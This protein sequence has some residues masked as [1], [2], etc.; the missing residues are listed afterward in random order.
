MTIKGRFDLTVKLPPV[1]AGDWELR[2]FT[3]M[4]FPS[5]GIVQ[6]FIDEVPQGIPFDMRPEGN[7]PKVG[8]KSDMEL[9]EEE[10]IAAFDRQFHNRGWM[11][12]PKSYWCSSSDA[13]GSQGDIFR[14]QHRTLRKV[15]GVFHSDGRTDHYLRLQQKMESDNN[16]LNFDFIELCPSSVYANPDIQEDRW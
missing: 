4:G 6:Y 5:R 2:M 15:I 1:P 11:K 9:G 16:E 8:W 12:G 14:D 13:G 3:C 10:L 7:D